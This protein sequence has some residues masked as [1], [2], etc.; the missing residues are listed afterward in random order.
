M[1]SP[2]NTTPA[3][4]SAGGDAPS[5]D[6][7]DG[8]LLAA[9]LLD[10]QANAIT[11]VRGALAAIELAVDAMVPVLR[12]PNGRLIYCGA[13]TSGRVSLLDAVELI[14]TFG[15]DESRVAVLL[16]GGEQSLYRSQENAEDD[17]DAARSELTALAVGPDDVV[18]GLA[19]SGTTPYVLAAVELAKASGAITIGIANNAD[20]PLLA[21]T[22]VPI[23][24]ATGP[25]ALAGSTRLTAGT[26]Q[27][28]ALNILSTA[29]IGAARPGV[30]WPHGLHAAQQH[31]VARPGGAHGR[32]P[33]QRRRRAGA[34]PARGRRIST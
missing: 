7:L 8:S 28:I 13:G 21:A 29:V 10:S 1:L 25:E 4:E 11:A 14:P 2:Q 5:L 3:T 22:D 26:S 12:R 34:R 9:T 15:W 17:G 6:E 24:L 30:P 16:A 33:C 23:L 32:G 27:K 31:Q 18:I 19:A 20:T